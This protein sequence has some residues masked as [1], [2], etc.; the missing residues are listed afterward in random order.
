MPRERYY[1]TVDRPND[2]TV[3]EMKEY[4]RTA[5]GAW[6][7]G[8]DPDELLF[9]AKPWNVAVIREPMED[10]ERHRVQSIAQPTKWGEAVL[11]HLKKSPLEK[12][13][14]IDHD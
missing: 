10:R 4:I 8:M 7:G 5:V 3:N 1:V 13:L 9:N 2:V 6:R 14:R 11:Q 12:S